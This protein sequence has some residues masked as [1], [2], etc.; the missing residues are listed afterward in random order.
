MY[1]ICICMHERTCEEQTREHTHTHERAHIQI[2]RLLQNL[3][4]DVHKVLCLPRNLNLQV[5]IA[6]QRAFRNHRTSKDNF[7]IPKRSFLFPQKM[8]PVAS[9]MFIMFT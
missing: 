2:P 3:H 4:I 7:E 5:H 1:N 9:P 6:Q 8:T